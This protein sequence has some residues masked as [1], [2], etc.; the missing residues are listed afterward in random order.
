MTCALVGSPGQ[1]TTHVGA[2]MTVDWDDVVGA[3]EVAERLNVKPGTVPSW[4]ARGQMPNPDATKS[5]R[6]LWSWSATI[7]PWARETGRLSD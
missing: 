6:P 2:N 3:D 7:E 5:G 1:G 4:K